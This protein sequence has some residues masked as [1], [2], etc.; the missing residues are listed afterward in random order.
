MLAPVF[1]VGCPRSGTSLLRNLLRSHPNLTF[2]RESH[3]IPGF[4][5][6]YGNPKSDREAR[7]LATRVL[8]LSW[9]KRW[10]LERSPDEFAD[11]RSF[12]EFVCRLFEGWARHENK[13]RWG[14]KTPQHVLEIPTLL[15]IFPE[16]KI[17]HVCRDGRDVAL[18]W[19]LAKLDPGNLYTAALKWRTWVSAGRRAGSALSSGTYFELKYE[20]LL[21]DLRGTMQK[22]CEFLDEPFRDEVL[23]INPLPQA[24]RVAKLSIP[25]RDVVSTNSDKWKKAMSREDR[26]LFESVAGDL[27]EQLGYKT[28]GPRRS[29]SPPEKLYWKLHHEAVYWRRRSRAAFD[30]VLVLTAL[31]FRMAALKRRLRGN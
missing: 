30:P 14:D 11:C 25:G 1:I 10:G 24:E 29:V 9:L 31:E 17:I 8:N 28:S 22:V 21:A 6:A 3:F 4:Y 7:E 26:I 18:S 16:A 5:R 13:P 15:E 20:T 12:R 27:L 2:P 19:L 23:K